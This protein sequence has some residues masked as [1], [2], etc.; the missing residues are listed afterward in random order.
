MLLVG[1][2]SPACSVAVRRLTQP[3]AVF[4]TVNDFG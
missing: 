4:R 1:V 2:L 3:M